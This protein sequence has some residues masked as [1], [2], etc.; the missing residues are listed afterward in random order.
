SWLVDWTVDP[1]DITASVRALAALGTPY[2]S[3][4]ED[5]VRGQ[6]QSQGQAIVES[7][8]QTGIETSWD[9]EIIAMIAYLQRLG[10]DGNAVFQA[11]GSQ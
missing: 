5:W 6:M 3:T 9:R 10:R 11:E 7:L 4:E 8:A 2:E 1:A